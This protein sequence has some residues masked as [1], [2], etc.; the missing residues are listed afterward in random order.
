MRRILLLAA[1]LAA[2]AAIMGSPAASLAN[3]SCS[4]II[5][6]SPATGNGWVRQGPISQASCT[7]RWTVVTQYQYELSGTWHYPSTS[8]FTRAGN[9]VNCGLDPQGIYAGDSNCYGTG[10]GG[11]PLAGY[12]GAGNLGTWRMTEIDGNVSGRAPC[13][14]NWRVTESLFDYVNDVPI[15]VVHSSD[16]TQAHCP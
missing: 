5:T 2:F 13:S 12:F 1:T 15:G 8:D 9:G 16:V 6:D 14:L 11:Y 4:N 10:T 7:V 3:G